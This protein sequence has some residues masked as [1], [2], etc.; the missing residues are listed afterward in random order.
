VRVKF[1][2]AAGLNTASVL[3]AALTRAVLLATS[4]AFRDTRHRRR[5]PI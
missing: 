3:V 5:D 1:T 4:H 2:G